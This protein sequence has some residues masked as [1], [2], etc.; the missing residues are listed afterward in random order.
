M[1]EIVTFRSR[2]RHLASLIE[3]D[4]HR[5]GL[6]VGEPY[7]TAH[8]VGQD[9][10]V[11]AQT[12]NR[13]MKL[14]ANRGLLVRK[15]GQGTFVGAK[16]RPLSAVRL[17][18]VHVL[19]EPYAVRLGV[20]V[21][22][23]L[24][25]LLDELPGHDPQFN[26]LPPYNPAAYVRKVL[27][28]GMADGSLCGLILASCPREVQEAVLASKLPAVVL[29]SVYQNTSRL[30]SVEVDQARM[31][32][33][34]TQYLLE[35]GHR[36][37]GLLIYEKWM[38]GDNRFVDGVNQML[39]KALFNHAGLVI[40][41]IPGEASLVTGELGRL[42]SLEDRP[43]GLIC[44][45]RGFAEAAVTVAES[46]GLAVPDDLEIVFRHYDPKS[47]RA[48]ALPYACLELDFTALAAVVGRML[49]QL[50]EG[51]RPEPDHVV[52]PVHLVEPAGTSAEQE[53]PRASPMM[54]GS[55]ERQ[56][57]CL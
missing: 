38:P 2:V 17:K 20:P 41:S 57:S 19:I 12:A 37:I 33:M 1:S 40:R 24:E 55:R 3:H 56:S 18:Y 21:G 16:M 35:R 42:L 54:G 53:T 11:H 23:L 22:E 26:Y 15:R 8:E 39:G 48:L 31:G 36:R 5:K 6:S 27:Q 44:G 51:Q 32:R 49:R 52:L 9:L 47:S 46:L 7:L 25:G 30:P 14:L 45:R 50:I 34:L 43:T 28:K 13:A 4:I 10:G 29:G